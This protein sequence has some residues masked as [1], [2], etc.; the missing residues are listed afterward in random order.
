M[1]SIASLHCALDMVFHSSKPTRADTA[2]VTLR[3]SFVTSS[4]FVRL[5][6]NLYRDV[7]Q[8]III[9]YFLQLKSH[10]SYPNLDILIFL[11][12]LFLFYNIMLLLLRLMYFKSYGM[13]KS[14]G[15]KHISFFVI[16]HIIIKFSCKGIQYHNRTIAPR[17]KYQQ[18]FFFIIY[19]I[20]RTIGTSLGVIPN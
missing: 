18:V 9:T 4:E 6:T 7:F 10:L 8:L 15:K 1:Q 13:F 12:D 20:F 16:H 19:H 5:R 17:G 2:C 11:S 14:T 3:L